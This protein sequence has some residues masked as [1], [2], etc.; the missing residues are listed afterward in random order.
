MRT[1]YPS[2]DI[3]VC[4]YRNRELTIQC[5]DSLLKLSYPNFK[6]ILVD[7]YSNDGTVEIL[8]EKYSRIT[9]IENKKNLGPARARNIGIKAGAGEYIVTMDNDATLSPDW[10]TKMIG[11]MK[12]D[13]KI[14]Q[15]VGKILF[16][17]NPQK[18]AAAGGS[19]YFRGKAYDIGQG[20]PADS[21]RYGQK[22]NILFACT[23][24]SI[25]L[26]SALNYIGGFYD[27][28][29]HGYEDTD[30]SFRL[31]ISGYGVVYY[32]E[33][34]SFH[35]LSQTVSQKINK[36]RA[37]LAIR[38]R[39]LIMFR[40]Y[41]FKSLIKYLPANIKFSIT[42]CLRHPERTVYV[43]KGWL[44]ILFHFYGIFKSRKEIN[45]IRKS[46]DEQLYLLFNLV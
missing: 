22:R 23:A 4:G 34:V 10:L 5:I 18:L 14:G 31:N 20:E 3:V 42:D 16:L 6:I 33:A 38:N 44:W 45:R 32:P 12:S 19:M 43:L 2:V 24:S 8:R 36:K 21:S 11:L 26:R 25:I 39:L 40:N 28:Y 9:I 15:A 17:D 46:K 37:Y 13:K 27:I 30:F 35:I 29:Y 1:N 7:D 41:E